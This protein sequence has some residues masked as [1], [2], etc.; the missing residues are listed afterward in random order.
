MVV[1]LKLGKRLRGGCISLIMHLRHILGAEPL[2]QVP[3]NTRDGGCRR[4]QSDVFAI[5][6]FNN[7]VYYSNVFYGILL[8]LNKRM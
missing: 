2:R 1:G 8:L 7:A 4:V 3:N 5:I 6:N